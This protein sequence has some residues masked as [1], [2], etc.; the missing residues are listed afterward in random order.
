MSDFKKC[1]QAKTVKFGDDFARKDEVGA[2]FGIERMPIM[3][4]SA[5]INRDGV[6]ALIWWP[7]NLGEVQEWIDIKEVY[8]AEYDS[9]GYQEV[10]QI[11]ETNTDPEENRRHV[12]ATFLNEYSQTRYVFW[13]E[14]CRGV[15]WYKFYGVYKLM[16]EKTQETGKCWFERVATRVEL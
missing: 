1:L 13:H 5:R 6:P 10:L 16:R 9:H 2:L 8:G 3:R 7:N 15:R 4:G 12:E 11:S 14:S